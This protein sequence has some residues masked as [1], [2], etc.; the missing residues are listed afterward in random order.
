M[1]TYH[2]PPDEY[3]PPTNCEGCGKVIMYGPVIGGRKWM[4]VAGSDHDVVMRPEGWWDTATGLVRHGITDQRLEDALAAVGA[5]GE[6][7]A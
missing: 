1:N 6:T 3:R 4:H 5:P 2:R 7:T